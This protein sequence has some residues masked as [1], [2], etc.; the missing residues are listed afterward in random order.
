[1]CRVGSTVIFRTSEDL[2]K[3]CKFMLSEFPRKCRLHDLAD[4]WK[5]NEFRQFL[6][7]S[8]PVTLKIKLAANNYEHIWICLWAFTL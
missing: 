7:Y 4:R 3:Y 5:A 6:P 8:G 2:V 1:M